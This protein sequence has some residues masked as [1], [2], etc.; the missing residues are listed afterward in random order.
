[1]I[2]SLRGCSG[3]GKSTVAFEI[4]KRWPFEE[5]LDEKGKI[6]GYKGDIGLSQPLLIVGKYKTQ[7]GGCDSIHTQQEIY[8]RVVEYATQGHVLFEGLLLSG[9]YGKVGSLSEVLPDFVF[10]TLDTPLDL[11]LER[12]RQRR[13][14]KNNFT[15]L[16]PKNTVSKFESTRQVHRRMTVEGKRAVWINHTNAVEEVL[17]LL[18]EQS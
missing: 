6:R 16:N 3:A 11:C 1:M 18:R 10:A 5:L 15:P 13:A 2:V 14:A 8:D 9:G 17:S 4:M 12:V 7:C